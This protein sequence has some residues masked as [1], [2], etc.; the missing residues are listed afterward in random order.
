MPSQTVASM[1]QLAPIVAE[2]KLE[3]SLA[4]SR[5]FRAGVY[6][7]PDQLIAL[8][9]PLAEDRSSPLDVAELNTLFAGLDFLVIDDT[10]GSGQ[11]LA[12]EIWKIFVALMG[13]ALLVEAAL[14]MPPKTVPK[15][16]LV[17]ETETRRSAA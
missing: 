8:N 7:S 11:S 10:L 5:P 3:E 9:R 15:T 13:I 17:A 12:S 6:G 2:S 4:Q 16:L 1:P 14:C